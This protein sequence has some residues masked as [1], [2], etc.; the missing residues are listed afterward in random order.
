MLETL[1]TLPLYIV[2]L[3]GLFW[4]GEVSLARITFVEAENFSLWVKGNRHKSG[5]PSLERFFWPFDTN[6]DITIKAEVKSDNFRTPEN[7]A[8][9]W[10]QINTGYLIGS[11]QRSKWSWGAA[12]FHRVFYSEISTGETPGEQSEESAAKGGNVMLLSRRTG[13]GSRSG[14][15][16]YEGTDRNRSGS[17]LFM[18]IAGSDWSCITVA[19]YGANAISEYTRNGN[20]VNWS[21]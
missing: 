8:N 19:D 15:G 9:G 6:G 18:T 1:L 13:N 3:A 5:I 17:S 2:I 10:G 7:S 11:T 16:S 12:D 21:D 14:G 4:L 20:C